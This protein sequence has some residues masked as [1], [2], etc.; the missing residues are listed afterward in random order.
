[1]SLDTPGGP[2]PA[3]GMSGKPRT[4]FGWGLSKVLGFCFC[5]VLLPVLLIWR[6]E[7]GDNPDRTLGFFWGG[8]VTG[9]FAR[10]L[11][12]LIRARGAYKLLVYDEKRSKHLPWVLPLRP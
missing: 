10:F 11:Y 2:A 4:I 12:E 9:G 1:M 5:G 3:R 7:T 8:C 6:V